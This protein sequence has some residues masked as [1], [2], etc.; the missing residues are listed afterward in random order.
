M[1]KSIML[2]GLALAALLVFL[3][4]IE[5]EYLLRDISREAYIAIVAVFFLAVGVWAGVRISENI[6]KVRKQRLVINA[7]SAAQ[8]PFTPLSDR[9]LE[10]LQLLAEGHS[11]QEIADRLFIS[12]NTVKTH[13]TNLYS[14]LGVSRRTQAVRKARELNILQFAS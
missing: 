4:T 5:Y 2:Y 1:R 13:T 11:N 10:V 9:E 14:K 8:L 6:Q 3:K 12:L 7:D